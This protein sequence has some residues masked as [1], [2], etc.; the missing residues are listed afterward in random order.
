MLFHVISIIMSSKWQRS[1]LAEQ[2]SWHPGGPWGQPP[3]KTSRI[4]RVSWAERP[5]SSAK[6][7]LELT[8]SSVYPL[9]RSF[10]RE[11]KEY[12]KKFLRNSQGILN[13]KNSLRTG[14]LSQACNARIPCCSGCERKLFGNL[15]PHHDNM[16]VLRHL[17]SAQMAVR[18]NLLSLISDSE[19]FPS[20]LMSC[21]HKRCAQGQ[22]NSL[23]GAP[24]VASLSLET[25]M[26][27]GFAHG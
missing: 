19:L 18:S 3:Q 17:S 1:V 26:L 21:S 2:S 27:W 24:G 23:P 7:T 14:Q 16:A 25:T 12:L 9:L 4:T 13:Q 10:K 20:S 6:G 15:A 8:D 5:P 22:S 11:H